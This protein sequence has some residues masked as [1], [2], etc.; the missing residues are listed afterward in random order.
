MV[1]GAD[2]C[3]RLSDFDRLLPE[4]NLVITGEGKLDRK[5][6]QGKLPGVI[7]KRCHQHRIPVIA[8]AGM[9]DPLLPGFDQI[10]TLAEY[11][12]NP[13]T[14]LQY[15]EPYLRRIAKDLKRDILKLI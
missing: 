4:A 6:L 8:I 11:A 15:P 13:A 3:L 9:A 5:S 12:G 7:A 2:F 1:S 10:Y 14:S